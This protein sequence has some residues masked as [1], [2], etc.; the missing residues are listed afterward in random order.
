MNAP[1]ISRVKRIIRQIRR[2]E[3]IL[4]LGELLQLGTA[5]EVARRLE[6]EMKNRFPELFGSDMADG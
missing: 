3:S 4:L 2:D 6:L 1:S 5:P